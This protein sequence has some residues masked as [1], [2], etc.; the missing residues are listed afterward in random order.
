MS[1]E[2]SEGE[3]CSCGVLKASEAF[4][5]W[6]VGVMSGVLLAFLTLVLAF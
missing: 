6:L 3:P 2:R 4:L 1:G 5:W